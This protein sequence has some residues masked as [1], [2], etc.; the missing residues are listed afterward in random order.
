M[1]NKKNNVILKEHEIDTLVK[2]AK[3][4]LIMQILKTKSL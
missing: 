4:N 1:E 3:K 2:E